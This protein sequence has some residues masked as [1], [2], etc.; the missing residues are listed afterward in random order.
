MTNKKETIAAG[1]FINMVRRNGWEFVERNNTSAI[2]VILAVT[3]DGRMI[4]VEQF[5]EPVEKNVIELPAGLAGDHPG[6]EDE[7]IESAA[8]RELFEETGYEAETFE[9]LIEGPPSAGLSDEILTFVRA[10]GLKRTGP[11]GGESTENITVHEIPPH[12]AEGW[13]QEQVASGKVVD[14]KVLVGLFYAVR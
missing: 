12:S 11:G 1:R 5:R 6:H 2:V 9:I 3:E 14:P 4:F 13:L 10:T 7:A 8:R